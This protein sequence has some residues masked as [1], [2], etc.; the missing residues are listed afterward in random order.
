M[1]RSLIAG[2]LFSSV[3]APLGACSGT[4]EAT[5]STTASSS[6]AKLVTLNDP[7]AR[8]LRASLDYR[9]NGVTLNL[10]RRDGAQPCITLETVTATLNGIPMRTIR[11]GG[12]VWTPTYSYS[13]SSHYG[14]SENH[15]GGCSS[16]YADEEEASRSQDYVYVCD[17]PAFESIGTP[18]ASVD[19]RLFD[20]SGEIAIAADGYVASKTATIETP[21]PLRSGDTVNVRL[22]PM[23]AE[24]ASFVANFDWLTATDTVRTATGVSFRVQ[25][26]GQP[27]SAR[28]ASTA[29]ADA[30]TFGQEDS[31]INANNS[32][33]EPE[34]TKLRLLVFEGWGPSV[35]K[36]S[37]V[38][39]CSVSN[40]RDNLNYPPSE[41]WRDM[42]ELSITYQLLLP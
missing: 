10:T 6:T 26:I 2:L 37:G 35:S 18:P 9:A 33:R 8:A 40:G 22:E 4:P 25:T 32:A 27:G 23:P 12:M 15:A 38:D 21:M 19:I 3:V 31:G 42:F 1:N 14:D 24:G 17:E 34:Q 29:E 30:S 39:T 11:R 36:C 28:D 20:E 7:L 13:N 5:A 41:R 16:H